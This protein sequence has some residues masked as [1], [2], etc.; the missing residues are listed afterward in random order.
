MIKIG[1]PFAFASEWEK[2]LARSLN[3]EALAHINPTS[4]S[5]LNE[6]LVPVYIKV[7]R[8]RYPVDLAMLCI[9]TEE[10]LLR[11]NKIEENNTKGSEVIHIEPLGKANF[12]KPLHKV[13]TSDYLSKLKEV[14]PSRVVGGKFM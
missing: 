12:E 6:N 5:S 14:K 7:V 3:T 10:D 8:R 13:D 1:S 4:L 2:I 9:P 11:I